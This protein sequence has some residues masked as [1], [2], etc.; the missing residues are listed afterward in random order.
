MYSLSILLL[1]STSI[2]IHKSQDLIG[3]FIP[4]YLH[5]NSTRLSCFLICATGTVLG[6]NRNCKD[7][8]DTILSLID[9]LEKL[10][11]LSDLTSLAF[12]IIQDAKQE[13]N[14]SILTR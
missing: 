4:G 10:V 13:R 14:I 12:S 9:S 8:E 11:G 5:F 3:N 2:M 1:N 7:E 6:I